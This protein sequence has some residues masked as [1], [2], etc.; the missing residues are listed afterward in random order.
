[1]PSWLP[2]FQ[3]ES[4]WNPGMESIESWNGI[5][6]ILEWNPLNPGMESL[7]SWKGIRGIRGILEWNP[8]NPGI[9]EESAF[10]F[11]IPGMES[12]ES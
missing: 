6:G 5:R 7:K 4:A 10:F 3:L 9:T 1:M 8:W 2:L 11:W 12:V